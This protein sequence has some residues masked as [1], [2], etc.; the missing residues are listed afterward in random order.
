MLVINHVERA[1]RICC[2]E[3]HHGMDE[4]GASCAVEPC[5]TCDDMV[6]AELLNGAFAGKFTGA[7]DGLW[8][9]GVIFFT[10]TRRVTRK[11][12]VG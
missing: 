9:D 2:G 7:I 12:I 11:D 5:D 3:C 10:F 6:G 1:A 8:C 4:A